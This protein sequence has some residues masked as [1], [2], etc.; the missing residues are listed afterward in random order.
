MTR[1]KSKQAKAN[2]SSAAYGKRQVVFFDSFEEENEYVAKQRANTSYEKRMRDME[3]LRK[4]VFHNHLLPDNSWKPVAKIFKIMP[5]YT[6]D[7]SK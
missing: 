1:K 4:N 3:Q 6:H 5:P 7:D 2:E